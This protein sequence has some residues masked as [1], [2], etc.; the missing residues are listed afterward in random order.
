MRAADRAR[1]QTPQE[2]TD[3]LVETAWKPVLR[4]IDAANDQFIRTTDA[5][6]HRAGAGVLA[7]GCTTAATST[8]APTKGRTASAARSSSCP[9]SVEVMDGSRLCPIHK[10]PGRAAQRGQLLLRDVASTPTGCSSS[11]RRGRS[12]CKPESRATRSSRSSSRACRTCRSPVRRSTGASRCRGTT[13]RCSTSG[14]TRCS[15]T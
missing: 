12:R 1:R 4:T 14:S 11:T 5:R 10:T 3:E 7:D 2:W 9:A 8:R 6:P 15:T 13:R